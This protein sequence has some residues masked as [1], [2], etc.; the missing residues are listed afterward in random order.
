MEKGLRH[1]LITSSSSRFLSVTD[2]DQ[3]LFKL[4]NFNETVTSF[5]NYIMRPVRRILARKTL[6]NNC[7]FLL[8][9]VLLSS[10]LC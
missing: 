4:K 9:V 10:M 7:D 1:F 5:K 2:F 8:S 6:N 3:Y